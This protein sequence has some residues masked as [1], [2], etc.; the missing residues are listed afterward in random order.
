[1]RI[2]VGNAEKVSKE[3][4]PHV[5]EENWWK[6]AWRDAV[7]YFDANTIEKNLRSVNENLNQGLQQ[8][9]VKRVV[10]D[11]SN[12]LD[13]L[14]ALGRLEEKVAKDIA[15]PMAEMKL[16][17]GAFRVETRELFDALNKDVAVVGA[18]VD[19]VRADVAVVDEHVKGVSAHVDVANAR[20]EAE[21]HKSQW[22][23]AQVLSEI[24]QLRAALT[25]D[26][27]VQRAQLE[28][29]TAADALAAREAEYAARAR[30][31]ES[32]ARARE[33]E[34]A[35]RAHEAEAAAR[36]PLEQ[37]AAARLQEAEAA[38]T[39]VAEVRAAEERRLRRQRAAER[40]EKEQR[41][42][43]ALAYMEDLI[44]RTGG[45][46]P[47]DERKKNL[48][49]RG[50]DYEVECAIAA[51]APLPVLVATMTA[52]AEFEE[53]VAT[54]C[55][56][57]RNITGADD[58][59]PTLGAAGAGCIPRLVAALTTHVYS[60]EVCAPACG[61]LLNVSF[62]E[63][64][65]NQ[66][67]SGGGVAALRGA[68][69]AHPGASSVRDMA[70]KALKNLGYE[71]D[72]W[73]CRVCTCENPAGSAACGVC[74][75]S[76]GSPAPAAAAGCGGGGRGGGGG[77]EG[78]PCPLCT[79]RNHK[80]AVVCALCSSAPR[81]TP[82]AIG[83]FHSP[84]RAEAVAPRFAAAAAR[85]GGG[86]GGGGAGGLLPV[87]ARQL[88]AVSVTELNHGGDSVYAL[89]VVPHP[90]KLVSGGG[91]GMYLWENA[92]TQHISAQANLLTALSGGR[93]ASSREDLKDAWGKRSKDLTTF[94]EVWD[95]GT[96]AS[97]REFELPYVN[98]CCLAY[99]PVVCILAGGCSD[100]KVHLWSIFSGTVMDSHVG[101]LEGHE[102]VVNA[103]AVLPGGRLASGSRDKT[104]RLWDLETRGCLRTLQHDY[105]V[106]ALAAFDDGRLASGCGYSVIIWAAAGN[107]QAELE[108]H[109]SHVRSL[110]ALSNGLLASGSSDKTVRVW[111]LGARACVAVLEGHRG[112]VCALAALPDGHLASGSYDDPLIRVWTLK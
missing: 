75:F 47:M 61:A 21:V 5:K 56:V 25:P 12:I 83:N 54:A 36:A 51:A 19:A 94:V 99:V 28:K 79:Y 46:A 104:V 24:A 33:T 97:L 110:A 1:M 77:D 8:I 70:Q 9:I 64:L 57:L 98:V 6:R 40:E 90:W 32:A 52:N 55:V 15:L 45:R 95:A 66:V 85:G 91:E 62:I 88:K 84:P 67:V 4:L 106:L 3:S 101:T 92:A 30:E 109:T 108:G 76:P 87:R 78:W 35:A 80:G 42:R 38:H 14:D 74:S 59:A 81:P 72:V 34:S 53:V 13:V 49:E 17:A 107:I 65:R 10:N 50:K 23:S 22:M 39:R 89:A 60:E 26:A 82:P 100:R 29:A 73:T 71:C 48:R 43:V 11:G 27:E 7:L 69:K 16:V 86:G 93:F 41:A 112:W 44:E 63:E 103:L 2:A 58:N 31:A 20:L 96:R 37:A 111:D 68:F 105:E 18:K 102:N